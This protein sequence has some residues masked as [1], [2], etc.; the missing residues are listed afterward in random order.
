MKFLTLQQT[1][2][3][4]TCSWR[5]ADRQAAQD[6]FPTREILSS[7]CGIPHIMKYA[8]KNVFHGRRVWLLNTFNNTLHSTWCSKEGTIT[9]SGLW[10]P[11]IWITEVQLLHGDHLFET[12]PNPGRLQGSYLTEFFLFFQDKSAKK[13]LLACNREHLFCM[14]TIITTRS[15][16]N[17]PVNHKYL[18]QVVA[19]EVVGKHCLDLILREEKKLCRAGITLQPK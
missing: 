7:Y 18:I 10:F 12:L 11:L 4:V 2:G 3:A 14:E 8:G 13:V 16:V 15:C 9:F 6:T 5:G 19:E 17:L 1:A